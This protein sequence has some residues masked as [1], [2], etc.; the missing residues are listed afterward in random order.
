MT[1]D[2][3][4]DRGDDGA[5]AEAEMQERSQR[6]GGMSALDPKGLAAAIKAMDCFASY[7]TPTTLAEDCI[8]A[9]L[10]ATP[11]KG[12]AEAVRDV[13]IAELA[14]IQRCGLRDRDIE[15][16]ADRIL[17]ALA[18]APKGQAEAVAW[19]VGGTVAFTDGG[20]VYSPPSA[21]LASPAQAVRG[22][23]AATIERCAKIAEA[24]ADEWLSG[25]DGLGWQ[26][27]ASA[28]LQVAEAIRKLLPAAPTE[29]K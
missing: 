23:E 5:Q 6:I 2:N 27:E 17:A 25:P 11:P 26:A 16:T 4:P 21:A 14:D 18:P 19:E 12:Q 7:D 1:R 28:C 29:S 8:R 22:V 15:P 10:E 20:V 3:N 13:L 9:Y 24:E